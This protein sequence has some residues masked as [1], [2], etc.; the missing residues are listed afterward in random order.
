MFEVFDHNVPV[1]QFYQCPTCPE[2]T[3]LR[4]ELCVPCQKNISES[5]GL[6]SPEVLM[7]WR[8]QKSAE[9]TIHFQSMEA[10][11][12]GGHGIQRLESTLWAEDSMLALNSI[13]TASLECR[14]HEFARDF[15]FL[16]Q[17]PAISLWHCGWKCP[18]SFLKITMVQTCR[19]TLRAQ[20]CFHLWLILSSC[21]RR[22]PLSQICRDLP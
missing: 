14:H 16:G 15:L 5:L 4:F 8:C 10:V 6:S 3:G 20:S 11:A 21:S 1:L 22:R 13:C 18:G 12:A 2:V 7:Q 9:F 17:M 19:K